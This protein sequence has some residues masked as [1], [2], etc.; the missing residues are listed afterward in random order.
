MPALDLIKI[1]VEKWVQKLVDTSRRNNLLFLKRG[2]DSKSLIELGNLDDEYFAKFIGGSIINIFKFPKF[3]TPNLSDEILLKIIKKAEENQEEKGLNTL[4][5]GAGIVEFDAGDGGRGYCAPLFLLPISF[6]LEQGNKKQYRIFLDGNIELNQSLLIVLKNQYNINCIDLVDK[7]EG[8]DDNSDI[9]SLLTEIKDLFFERCKLLPDFKLI[10]DY[11]ISNFSFQKM[12]MVQD[13]NGA[14]GNSLSENILIRALC[15]D[16][17]AKQSVQPNQ[18]PFEASLIDELNPADDFT[19]LSADSSQFTAIRQILAG[20]NGVIQGPP[21]TGKSQTIAN[22]IGE[23]VARHKKVLFV[24]E[25]SAALQVVRDRLKNVGLGDLTINLHGGEVKSGDLK[26][27]LSKAFAM[28]KAPFINTHADDMQWSSTRNR[29]NEHKKLFHTPIQPWN[30]TTYQCYEHLLGFKNRQIRHISIQEKVLEKITA[31]NRAEILAVLGEFSNL[32]VS[33]RATSPWRKIEV[34]KENTISNL[35][36][37]IRDYQSTR[38]DFNQNRIKLYSI[39]DWKEPAC[40]LDLK[41]DLEVISAYLE[42]TELIDSTAWRNSQSDILNCLSKSKDSTIKHY[43]NYLLNGNYRTLFRRF[44]N[45]SL[46]VDISTP[47]LY[48]KIEYIEYLKQHRTTSKISQADSLIGLVSSLTGYITAIEK[49]QQYF[50]NSSEDNLL[51]KLHSEI[52]VLSTNHQDGFRMQRINELTLQ[53]EEFGLL[54]WAQQALSETEFDIQELFD[55]N[56]YNEVLNKHRQLNVKVST[57]NGAEFEKVR[58]KFIELDEDKQRKAVN[59]I[60]RSHAEQMV[61]TQNAYPEQ[62]AFLTNQSQKK[63]PV[64]LRKLFEKAPDVLLSVFPVWMASPLSVT[65]L[66]DSKRQYFDVVIFDEAS[67]IQPEDAIC[68][69][70][71]GKQLVVA[72]DTRQLPPSPFFADQSYSEEEETDVIG[73]DGE[74]IQITTEGFESLLHMVLA[75]LPKLGPSNYGWLLEWHYRSKDEALIAFSNTHI[76]NERLTTF[77][78][79]NS[80]FGVEFIR[81]N[82]RNHSDINSDSSSAEVELVVNIAFKIAREHPEASIGIIALGIKHANRI[83]KYFQEALKNDPDLEEYFTASRKEKFF[84][85]NL[86]RVQGDERDFIILSTGF[87]KNANGILNHYFGP[88]NQNGGERRLNVAITRARLGM[89]V[90]SSFDPEDINPIKTKGKKGPELLRKYL[91]FAKSHGR[92]LQRDGAVDFPENVFEKDVRLALEKHGLQMTPQYGVSNYRIDIVVHHPE[93]PGS[94]IMAIECDGASY[95]SAPCARDRDRLRQ[96]HLESMGW[97]FARVWSTDWFY[98]REEEIKRILLRYQTFLSD[99]CIQDPELRT[100]EK[101]DTS[102][103]NDVIQLR[104]TRKPIV[105]NRK[106]INDYTDEELKSIVNWIRSDN[107]LRTNEDIIREVYENLP[108]KKLGSKIREKILEIILFP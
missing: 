3:K 44:K 84:I 62:Q 91:L 40:L 18:A 10:E 87:Q 60:I 86:E 25:K 57:F 48:E 33:V 43:Y 56:Y 92:D 28:Q 93:K 22:L 81:A 78:S 52:D 95:H 107:I 88:I 75:N 72:G 47:L 5:V 9:V 104:R 101:S 35:I 2:S 71:R 36:S 49:L 68:S 66:T 12:V 103:N 13:L 106:S 59:R 17:S 31:D 20:W 69:I 27:Q 85:K 41:M 19:F 30:L 73:D 15:G 83:E 53:L 37:A 6:E 98:Y 11:L 97:K 38:F 16:E 67:Q 90:V 50:K 79:P 55:F 45:L 1:N 76:Y 7:I 39:L 8:T 102:D 96:K 23:L 21:G 99:A 70:I 26:E 32:Q 100:N 64:K 108:F 42:F 77:P 24:A 65:Q 14:L 74:P 105:P 46:N 51:V 4:F 58:K 63:R 61:A 80:K 29:L 82:P 94:Y 54:E 89:T 34:W